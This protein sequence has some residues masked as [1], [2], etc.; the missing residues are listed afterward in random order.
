MS[1]KPTAHSATTP[2]P[3]DAVTSRTMLVALMVPMLMMVLNMSMFSVSLPTL[4]QSFGLAADTT[5]WLLTAYAL[6]MVIFMPLYGRLGDGL[7]KRRL[8]LIGI[9][10]FLVGTVIVPFSSALWLVMVGRMIQ[11]FGA[12]SVNPLCIAIISERFLAAER[13]QAL[14]TWNSAG[15]IAGIAGP[16]LGGFLIDYFGWR[17]IFAVIFIIAVAAFWAVKNYIPAGNRQ[18]VNREYV[19]AFD[20]VGVVL[21]G[22]VV[23]GV[24]FFTSSRPI[25]GVSALQDLRLLGVTVLFL[26]LFVLW[27]KR[28]SNPF[29]PLGMFGNKLFIVASVLSGVRMWTLVGAGFLDT[30][31][32][33]DVWYLGATEVGSVKMLTAAGLL[34]TM[35]LGGTLA[36][37]WGSRRPVMIGLAVQTVILL[38][39]ARVPDTAMLSVVV[40]LILLYGLGAGV[41]LAPMHRSAMRDVDPEQM[42]LASGLYGM[43]R[44]GG[45]VM[46][47]A[48]I[49]VVLD[50]GLAYFDLPLPAYQICYAFT[51]V[52]SL[53]GVFL[54]SQ[55]KEG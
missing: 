38:T 21:L 15:P 43:I 11:G 5:A 25:T 14:G 47:V 17:T 23:T 18:F 54:A 27:E 50:A 49:G 8:F 40:F 35:R 2:S 32:L 7:G 55:L 28:H 30:L 1:L 9:G 22:V 3:T 26:M 51:A 42:G 34:I 52:V 33:T 24:V 37:R 36:D 31:Y 45:M 53:L 46:G 16:L 12:A 4:R 41:S 6:P 44:F 20:W 19:G 29:V 13:G 48:L 39:L 10:T